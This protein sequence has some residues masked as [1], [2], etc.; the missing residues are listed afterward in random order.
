M[1]NN[2]WINY[3]KGKDQDKNWIITEEKF[4]AFNQGKFE[5]IFSTGNGYI[6]SRTALE[7]DYPGKHVGLYVASTFD[8]V[9]GPE[10]SE[11]PNAANIWDMDISI[12]GSKFNMLVGNV[13]NYERKINLKNGEVTREV[14]WESDNG[15]NLN[16]EFKRFVSLSDLH[17]MSQRAE[18][19]VEQDSKIKIGS[20]INAQV[21]NSGAQHF[22]DTDSTYEDNILEYVLTT[23]E[24]RIDFVWNKIINIYVNGELISKEPKLSSVYGYA[25]RT[26]FEINEIDLTSG[27]ELVIEVIT[28]L[29]TSRDIEYHSNEI[30]T[31]DLRLK[32]RNEI[33]SISDK[34]YNEL[35]EESNEEWN[36]WWDEMSIEI[37]TD[38]DWDILSTRFA[39]YQIRRFTPIHDWRANIEAKGFAGEEYKGHTFWD[40]EIFIWPY[41]LYTK[42]EVAMNLL[43]HRHF[44]KNS[45]FIKG[46]ENGFDG[47]MWPWETTWKD[48]G[49]SCPT[50]GAVDRK[51][52]KRIK[53]WPAYN[54]L[55][56]GACITWA[57]YQ[58]F[59]A[60]KDQEFMNEYGYEVFFQTA[61]FWTN[62]LE[63]NK[64][65]DRYEINQV[66][67]PNEYKENIN[68]NAWTNYMVWF[69]LTKTLE[70]IET[71]RD[72]E[73][74]Q[75]L[76]SITDLNSLEEKINSI[77]DKIYLP[78][79]NEEGIIPENDSFLGLKQMDTLFYKENPDQLW[80]DYT[81]PELNDYQV[82]KQADI[83]A[84]MYTL[85]FLFEPEVIQKNWKYYEDRTFH[86][87]SLSL[88]MHTIT[89]NYSK[90][91]S[92]AYDFFLKAS[93]IDLGTNM[94]SC[95]N[96]IHSAS[97][98][99]MLQSII[100]GFGG[101]KNQNGEFNIEPNLPEKWS[102]LKYNFYLEG[103]K[104]ITTLTKDKITFEKEGNKN[105]S[106][107]FR[108]EDITLENKLEITL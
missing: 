6:G 101:I 3:Y 48:K 31:E 94:S 102:K 54:Q 66:T 53:V 92:F 45:A 61:L 1:E 44:V 7:E 51:E 89:A 39:Q 85:G 76:N 68:N 84:L 75:K 58:Y 105:V 10:V 34:R 40:T 28:K 77:V 64:D 24:S 93:A 72:L 32:T 96:G 67:G 97:I 20:G 90:D 108:G 57:I 14:E 59:V 80:K 15:D 95:D 78:Q 36:K 63:Y 21:T 8:Q 104:I 9:A 11:L 49:E 26:L 25:R 83:V 91:K 79:P 27:D 81:F 19:K 103:Q 106:F 100:V 71:I 65:L 99:G 18:I 13:K 52:G 12:N 43:K 41:F 4:D 107:K 5:V 30:S 60:T 35:L 47:M 86:H 42:P 70:Y 2:K 50:W 29:N 82:L 46:S 73:Q 16:V 23:I 69:N 37:E 22:E 74:Y 87:S 38:Q 62:R 98:G 17:L 55:H 88:S 33:S 56:I